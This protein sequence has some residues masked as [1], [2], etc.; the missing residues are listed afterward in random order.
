MKGPRALEAAAGRVSS[1]VGGC[2]L[3]SH[4]MFR[5]RDLHRELKDMDWLELNVF[6]ITGRSF[7]REQLRLLHAIWVYTSYPDSRIWNNR[8]AALAGSSRSTGALGVAAA[9]AVSE[10]RIY[11]L[12]PCMAAYDFFA[13]A[14]RETQRGAKLESLVQ[15]ELHAQRGI[16]GYGR[17][18]TSEDERIAPLLQRV[19]ELGLEGGPH[20]ELAL[21][22]DQLLR[23]GRWR[24]KMNYAA[25]AT[26]LP[27]DMGF[28]RQEFYMYMVHVFLAG[29]AP[30]F[31]DALD[32]PEGTLLPIACRDIRYEG[33]PRRPW[34]DEPGETT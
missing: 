24:L 30:C 29:M 13:K 26:A 14:R 5:G 18:L 7:S 21:A 28:S 6:G 11:G 20:L 4:A 8:V 15:E 10:A 23:A 34:N 25:L 12:G 9:V 17:P 19:R 33:E 31:I 32:K 22:T 27:M 3:G 16:G 2:V 1:R